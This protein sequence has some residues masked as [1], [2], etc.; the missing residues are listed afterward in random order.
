MSDGTFRDE[1]AGCPRCGKPL[2]P[3]AERTNCESCRGVLIADKYILQVVIDTINQPLDALP[4]DDRTARE[5]NLI[6]PGCRN[7]MAPHSLYGIA[8][9]R[10][11][12][13]GLWFDGDELAQM[14]QK[15]QAQATSNKMSIEEKVTAGAYL[16]G[17]VV[18]NIL[19]F[20]YF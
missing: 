12:T 11:E 4:L 15:V 14:M 18:L 16:A 10:C 5:P 1:F 7:P 2:D 9:D 17:F 13:H 3:G 19:R 6:C 20:L 8:V